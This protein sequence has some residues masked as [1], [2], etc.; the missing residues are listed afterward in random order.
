MRTVRLRRNYDLACARMMIGLR[1]MIICLRQN[2]GKFPHAEIINL[3]KRQQQRK[4]FGK[5]LRNFFSKKFL[6]SRS[7]ERENGCRR[8]PRKRSLLFPCA[9]NWRRPCR[10][11]GRSKIFPLGEIFA[12]SPRATYGRAMLHRGLAWVTVYPPNPPASG[13]AVNLRKL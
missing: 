8:Q 6:K 2:E 3:N 11:F 7:A 5:F 12:P 10:P 4:V 9:S 1:R 13:N